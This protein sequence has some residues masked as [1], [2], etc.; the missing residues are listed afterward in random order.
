M[1]SDSIWDDIAL[2]VGRKL[3]HLLEKDRINKVREDGDTNTQRDSSADKRDSLPANHRGSGQGGGRGAYF[4]RKRMQKGFA[5]A[6]QQAAAG[7][8]AEKGIHYPDV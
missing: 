4:R 1:I 3:N 7:I 6:E 5:L 2:D 8:L